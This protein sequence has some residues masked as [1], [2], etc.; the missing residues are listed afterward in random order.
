[1]TGPLKRL[2][3]KRRYNKK[4]LK[5]K[6][7]FVDNIRVEIIALRGKEIRKIFFEEI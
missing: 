3:K 7:Y 2:C 1:M 4:Q 5:S 6:K